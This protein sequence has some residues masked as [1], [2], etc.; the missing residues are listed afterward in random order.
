MKKILLGLVCLASASIQA[1]EYELQFENDQISVAKAKIQPHEEIGLHRDVYPHVVIALKGG[2]ITRLEADGR[3]TE[4]QFPTGVAVI[5]EADP[6]DELHKSVNNSSE[7]V[8]LIIIQLKNNP[9]IV[10]N[11]KENSNDISVNIKIN[12]PTSDEFQ[13][14]VKSIPPAG[15]YSSSFNEW[16]SSFVHNMNQLVHLVESEKIFNSWWSVNTN[17]HLPQ[18]T[19][20]E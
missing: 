11:K 20:G 6:Q 15:K 14:F 3:E 2:T 8:E 4:V 5:R 17:A 18:E 7:P 1:L 13:E 10:A 16:K 19:E 9:P 12:C